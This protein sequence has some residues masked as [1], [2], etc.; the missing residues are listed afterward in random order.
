MPASLQR[1]DWD[2]HR[3]RALP[4]P[5]GRGWCQPLRGSHPRGTVGCSSLCLSIS[6]MLSGFLTAERLGV[7]GHGAPMGEALPS[8]WPV[9]AAA[10]EGA[11]PLWLGPR[12]GAP[13]V[14]R[15]PPACPPDS[16]WSCKAGSRWDVGA[17]S[18]VSPEGRGPSRP[19]G[20]REVAAHQ[21][22]TT[23]PR[24]LLQP[25]RVDLGSNEG[26]LPD[27]PQFLSR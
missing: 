18:P 25:L 1:D 5:L 17:W 2:P 22:F 23:P 14:A 27:G 20:K 16:E 7:Q 10:A 6:A 13:G 19:L 26:P 24:E 12:P 4:Q 9:D 11:G 15:L 3:V 8:K 21:F